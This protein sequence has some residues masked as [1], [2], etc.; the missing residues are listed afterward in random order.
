M[1]A[2][3]DFLFTF[4]LSEHT[5]D[6]HFSGFRS[7]MNFDD[8]DT[9]LVLLQMGRSGR[10]LRMAYI[11]R[12]VERVPSQTSWPWAIRQSAIYHSFNI[13]TE[14]SVWLVVKANKVLKKRIATL[15]E[16]QALYPAECHEDD[17]RSFDSSLISHLLVCEW[18]SEQW[19]WYVSYI[20]SQVQDLTRDVLT[21]SVDLPVELRKSPTFPPV[22][23][24]PDMDK[25]TGGG[26]QAPSAPAKSFSFEH[27]QGHCFVAAILMTTAKASLAL[28]YSYQQ[29]STEPEDLL[30]TTSCSYDRLS[31]SDRP[32]AAPAPHNISPGTQFKGRRY[33]SHVAAASLVRLTLKPQARIR[34][35][36]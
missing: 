32:G 9:R 3:L 11:M 27:L 26:V 29:T 2:F 23:N 33:C 35:E 36:S 14:R 5:K 7:E 19:R 1:P 25:P 21:E 24:K 10:E 8:G 4:G 13:E 34:L 6:F 31:E 20:E 30:D 16:D 18:A 22:S 15:C 12:G 28:S 17:L